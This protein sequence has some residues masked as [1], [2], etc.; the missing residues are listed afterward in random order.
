MFMEVRVD[1][2]NVVKPA[3]QSFD[4]SK[5]GKFNIVVLVLIGKKTVVLFTVWYGN[6]H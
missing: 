1:L 3:N 2:V 6:K 4:L 5:Y